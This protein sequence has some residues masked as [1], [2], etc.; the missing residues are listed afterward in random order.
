M[1]ATR[2]AQWGNDLYT[3]KRSYD[4]V[5][6]RRRWYAA[7]I[8][9][10]VITIGLLLVNGLNPS[11][12]FRGGSG[13]TVAGVT[14]TTQQIGVDAVLSVAPAENPR[15]TVVGGSVMRIQTGEMDTEEVR[16]VAA[17]LAE[18]YEVPLANVSSTVVGPTWGES[19]T[20]KA[21]SG[22]L[23]FLAL[24]ALFMAVY[25]RAWRM[26]AAAIVSLM[27]DL[28]ITVGVYA[29]FGWEVSPATVIG[30]LTILSYS[31]YDTVVVFDKV[32]EN[33]A[34]VL[35]QQ[36]F[37]YAELVNLA[38]NQTLV[39]SVN[40]SIVALL[41]VAGILFIGAFLLGA[42]T[43]RDIALALFVGMAVGTVL[44]VFFAAP[45]QVTLRE[46]EPAIAAHTTKVL[47][48][49]AA[50]PELAGQGVQRVRVGALL[51]G[52]HLGIRAQPRRRRPAGR[53]S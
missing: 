39:R 32:R 19:V 26:S 52:E 13:F 23:I 12:D 9:I 21:L 35:G 15:V 30:L 51:P 22:L 28:T 47:A 24:A 44:S 42:G 45:F 41:P 10:V 1:P 4:I 6:G 27:L 43:L 37:T 5:G 8:A 2:A 33:T 40:T 29:G 38:V 31:I 14:D 53:K 16:A 18:A 20:S 25:F 11:I 7:T 36:R 34:N 3:G 49:R 17:A 46:R 50:D 48:A